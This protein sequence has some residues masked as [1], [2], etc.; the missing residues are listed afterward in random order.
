MKTSPS[1]SR[2]L[3]EVASDGLATNCTIFDGGIK[4]FE[5]LL[6]RRPATSLVIMR[7]CWFLGS[8]A[9]LLRMPFYSASS[10]PIDQDVA[11]IT[12]GSDTPLDIL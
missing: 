5:G 9:V 4:L 8:T 10:L 1:L 3:A 2:A 6:V 7:C 12:T 11:T